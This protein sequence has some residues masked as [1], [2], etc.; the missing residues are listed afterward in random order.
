[1]QMYARELINNG[2]FSTGARG[3]NAPHMTNKD[4]ANMLLA[5]LVTN[6]P[7]HAPELVRYFGDMQLIA[8]DAWNASTPL[9]TSPDHTLKDLLDCF[10]D[11]RVKMPAGILL[12]VIGTSSAEVSNQ[13]SAGGPKSFSYF[14]RELLARLMEGEYSPL[15]DERGITRSSSIDAI[16]I[17]HIKEKVFEDFDP[18]QGFQHSSS[19]T[20]EE[21]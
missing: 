3:V 10:C 17:E 18:A 21:A 14:S 15:L 13:D 7:A 20:S 5:L 9:P 8:P 11:P 16:T 2:M 12:N 4:L 1:M 6:R 19:E